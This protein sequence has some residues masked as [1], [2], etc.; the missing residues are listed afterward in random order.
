MELCRQDGRTILHMHTTLL[1]NT[2]PDLQI[3]LCLISFSYFAGKQTHVF[4]IGIA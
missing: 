4:G 3:S 2:I 1:L